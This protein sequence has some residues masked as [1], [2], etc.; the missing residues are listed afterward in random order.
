MKA[1]SIRFATRLSTSHWLELAWCCD[2]IM[3]P[4]SLFYVF[5]VEALGW[6]EMW[7]IFYSNGFFFFLAEVLAFLE[8]IGIWVTDTEKECDKERLVDVVSSKSQGRIEVAALDKPSHKAAEASLVLKAWF[9]AVT[10]FTDE[11]TWGITRVS[12]FV[13]TVWVIRTRVQAP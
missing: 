12:N 10:P 3:L 1:S 11:E 5:D 9:C 8:D 4:V 6:S 2:T 13:K 7:T